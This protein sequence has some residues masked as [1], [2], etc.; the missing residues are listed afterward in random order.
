MEYRVNGRVALYGAYAAD[1][2]LDS[3]ALKDAV[4]MVYYSYFQPQTIA[5]VRGT[6]YFVIKS[7]LLVLFICANTQKTLEQVFKILIL[8]FLKFF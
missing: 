5:N 4:V 8:K 1:V 3:S 2:T 7:L 6:R